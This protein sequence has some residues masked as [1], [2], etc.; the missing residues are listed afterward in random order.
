[1][2]WF[3]SSNTLT[4][5][6]A[7]ALVAHKSKCY[8]HEVI[9]LWQHLLERAASNSEMGNGFMG[10][11]NFEEI[12]LAL[13]LLPGKPKLIYEVLELQQKI[14]DG[15]IVNWGKRQLDPTASERMRQHRER[16]KAVTVTNSDYRN[17]DAVT[18][19][20][21]RGDKKE[22]ITAIAHG[23]ARILYPPPSCPP[24]YEVVS[25]H[26]G[27]SKEAGLEEYEAFKNHY[28][29]R[30][31]PRITDYLG[32]WKNWVRNIKKGIYV[33]SDK[34]NNGRYGKQSKTEEL[35][36]AAKQALADTKAM[37]ADDSPAA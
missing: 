6:P 22:S 10:K 24:D 32:L 16:K 4:T 5:D 17:G 9:A 12:E 3:K 29:A 13:E 21:R 14:K 27:L 23:G 20:E 18:L 26:K 1:M 36:A 28:L 37:F 31:D 2:K 30:P 25:M 33:N 35:N 19:E 8:R 11:I 7:L 34:Q 15:C